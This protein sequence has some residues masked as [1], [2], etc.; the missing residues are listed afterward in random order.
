MDKAVLKT[1]TD[2]EWIDSVYIDLAAMD[3]RLDSDPLEFGPKR[4]NEKVAATRDMLSRCSL[5]F[6]RLSQNIQH[7][8]RERSLVET[9]FKLKKDD[10]TSNDPVVR[11]GANVADREALAR[12]RLKDLV[13]DIAEMTLALEELE[14]FLVVV[15]AKQTDLKDIQGRLKDQ[16]RLCHDE[17]SLSDGKWGVR[18]SGYGV[19]API[20][21]GVVHDI[22]RSAGGDLSPEEDILE[23]VPVK[24][25]PLA[26][27]PPSA[28]EALPKPSASSEDVDAFLTVDLGVLPATM[29]P[30]PTIKEEDLS[31]V[32]LDQLFA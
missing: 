17:I 9:T 15:K 2:T 12:H 25:T 19:Y 16:I 20:A 7:I 28:K 13:I 21:S 23:E 26:S 11:A 18:P 5:I 24:S 29:A 32:D 31:A 10:L 4:L 6:L 30:R 8:R 3:V 22:I 1:L 14:T 27:L